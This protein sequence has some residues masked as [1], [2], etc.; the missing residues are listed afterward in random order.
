MAQ[1]NQKPLPSNEEELIKH[2]FLVTLNPLEKEYEFLASFQKQMQLIKSFALPN[3]FGSPSSNNTAPDERIPCEI[4]NQSWPIGLLDAHQQ[5]CVNGVKENPPAPPPKPLLPPLLPPANSSNS[6]GL[7]IAVIGPLITEKL[8]LFGGNDIINGGKYLLACFDRAK[9]F[10]L[11]FKDSKLDLSNKATHCKDK[12]LETCKKLLIAEQQTLLKNRTNRGMV[13]RSAVLEWID[14]LPTDFLSELCKSCNQEEIALIFTAVFLS[15]SSA[16]LKTSRTALTTEEMIPHLKNFVTLINDP[17]LCEFISHMLAKECEL[18]RS[19]TARQLENT[20]V[21]LS[22]LQLTPISNIDP[23]NIPP[24]FSRYFGAAYPDSVSSSELS[25]FRT[26]LQS[27]LRPPWDAMTT[28]FK[29]IFGHPLGSP[30]ETL[31]NW[32]ATI[33]QLNDSRATLNPHDPMYYELAMIAASDPCSLNLFAVLLQLCLPFMIPKPVTNN[34]NISNNPSSPNKSNNNTNPILLPPGLQGVNSAYPSSS[35]RYDL[36]KFPHLGNITNAVPNSSNV[37][38][39]PNLISTS[40][41]NFITEI[42]FATIYSL[43]NLFLPAKAQFSSFATTCTKLKDSLE[44]LEKKLGGKELA[45]DHPDWSR[46]RG[47][48]VKFSEYTDCYQTH[49][50]Q[51]SLVENLIQ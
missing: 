16:T 2:I 23:K 12:V 6:S 30:K 40:S 8:K 1:S 42:F 17:N 44:K 43:H 11:S 51:P 48:F 41:Y 19:Q 39:N 50:F 33:L 9:K 3:F 14:S 28:V 49:I 13:I 22:M 45:L 4:C 15:L 38:P 29:K 18:A 24:Y 47:N 46:I 5:R 25:N 10:E 20:S 37:S 31:L 26:S 27:K 34:A 35:M 36:S 7:D 21:I 32:I